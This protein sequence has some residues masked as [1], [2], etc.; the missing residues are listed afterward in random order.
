[1]LNKMFWVV[2]LLGGWL[3]KKGYTEGEMWKSTIEIEER[4]EKGVFDI[5]VRIKKDDKNT[6]YN[7]M[8]DLT[9][10]DPSFI[11]VKK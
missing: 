10:P 9:N 5:F 3:N 7:M 2:L 6:T 8:I 1:M 4:E 11:D